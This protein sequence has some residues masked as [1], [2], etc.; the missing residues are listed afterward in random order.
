MLFAAAAP[1]SIAAA[2]TAVVIGALV[3]LAGSFSARGRVPGLALRM[4]WTLRLVLL[5]LGIQIVSIPFSVDPGHALRCL[6]GSW[7]WLFVP[8]FWVMLGEPGLARRILRLLAASGALAGLYGIIQHFVGRNW[9]KGEEL[10][11]LIGGGGYIAVGSLGHH[12]SYAGVL[13]P[14]FFVALGLALERRRAWFWW[15]AAAC[16]L[17]GLGFSYARTAWVG[18]AA[19][20][21]LLGCLRGRRPLL[22]TA[23][24]LVL[25]T[26]AA[27]LIEPAIGR[28][29]LSMF[30]IGETPRARLWLS[31]LRILGDHP[32][33]GGGLGSFKA[34]FAEYRL[35]GEYMSTAHPHND[36]LNVLVETGIP[37]GLAWIA[38]WAAFFRETRPRL[39]HGARRSWLPDALRA[40]TAALL[41]A[42]LGQCFSTDEKV[43]QVWYLLVAGALHLGG[44]AAG[45]GEA[46]G[47]G[48]GAPPA[49]AARRSGA[50][51]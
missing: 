25:I 20:L 12:L 33:I 8:L 2:Q 22:L 4:P 28:R 3:V 36:L 5:F 41:I 48:E 21:L 44:R 10:E 17:G 29:L 11:A 18:M 31:S 19:G 27:I 50:R 39:P 30:D 24:A 26:A 9:V 1:W 6:A 40:A 37:G 46:R 7:V 35:P 49:G 34:L 14:L 23:G 16:I 13:L 47:G 42:G 15:A 51:R 43:A 45:T 38:I 32:W